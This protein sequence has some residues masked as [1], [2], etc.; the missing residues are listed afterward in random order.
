M[1][2]GKTLYRRLAK[3]YH[4]DLAGPTDKPIHA[5]LM[6]EINAAHTRG[7]IET[8]K[9]IESLGATYLVYKFYAPDQVSHSWEDSAEE[10]C[11]QTAGQPRSNLGRMAAAIL[12]L[13][14]PYSLIRAM[15]DWDETSR[16]RKLFSFFTTAI[17]TCAFYKAWSLLG[18]LSNWLAA[19]G[20]PHESIYGLAVVLGRGLLILVALPC[21]G[22][23]CLYGF[24]VFVALL[25]AGLATG[26]LM[27]ILGA[28]H[29]MLA[30]LPPIIAVP[31][32]LWLG[33]T[34]LDNE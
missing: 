13:L 21:V 22:A 6:V 24:V 28:F 14:H 33:W 34:A 30:Y 19:N 18:V 7:D 15:N 17:W 11:Y 25:L 8:L 9:E 32:L 1:E 16:G 23:L 29:P 3:Q 20:H 10:T 26:I 12:G 2:S 31:V 27:H 5:R 4:P